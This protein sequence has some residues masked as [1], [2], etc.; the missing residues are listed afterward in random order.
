MNPLLE[1]VITG[2]LVGA[3][4]L[5]ASGIWLG[6]GIMVLTVWWSSWVNWS[7]ILRIAAHFGVK[8]A[9]IGLVSGTL[10]GFVSGEALHLIIGAVTG[11]L[12]IS[13]FGAKLAFS[14]TSGRSVQIR[15]AF[16]Y[17]LCGFFVGLILGGI[18]GWLVEKSIQIIW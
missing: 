9:G 3:L 8:G 11:S 2:A 17:G 12:S 13:F 6:F 4:L 7:D 16:A 10:I 5:G 1:S 14:D 18:F 15:R